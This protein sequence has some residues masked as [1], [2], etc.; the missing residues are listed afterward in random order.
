MQW[1]PAESEGEEEEGAGKRKT[2]AKGEERQ[3]GANAHDAKHSRRQPENNPGNRD[4]R[5]GRRQTR[6]R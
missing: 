3:R 5:T 2:A 4:E 1:R 6:R